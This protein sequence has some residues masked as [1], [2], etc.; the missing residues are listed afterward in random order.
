MT[1]IYKKSRPA[2]KFNIYT[3]AAVTW[4]HNIDIQ[5][6]TFTYTLTDST[7]N[8]VYHNISLDLSELKNNPR[9]V[10][11]SWWAITDSSLGVQAGTCNPVTSQTIIKSEDLVSILDRTYGSKRQFSSIIG[12]DD[13]DAFPI[14]FFVRSTKDNFTNFVYTLVIPETDNLELNGV[15]LK[16]QPS[17]IT[18]NT[19]VEILDTDLPWLSVFDSIQLSTDQT[20]ISAGDNIIVNVTC[21]NTNVSKVYLEQVLGLLDRTEVSLV[22]GIG[23]FTIITN[24]LM[25]GD[26]VKVKAGYKKYNNFTNFTTTLN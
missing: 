5:E 13:Y 4:N 16:P 6:N 21:G 24:T 15:E 26:I 23:R 10:D 11:Q 20:G 19:G 2:G 14:K 3:A 8:V 9:F 17:E 1:K 12:V 25:A 18:V 7:N 22:N